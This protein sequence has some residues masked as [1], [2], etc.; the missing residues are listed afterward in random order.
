MAPINLAE[1][2]EPRPRTT[3]VD[4]EA[5]QHLVE[6]ER[7]T[8][9]PRRLPPKYVDHQP[10]PELDH[11]DEEVVGRLDPDAERLTGPGRE[12]AK[13][14]GDEDFGA[15]GYRRRQHVAIPGGGWASSR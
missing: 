9:F 8:R 1:S 6:S 15:A 5:F 2:P 4:R 14:A 10:G 13:F 7:R 11:L 3:G 12:V